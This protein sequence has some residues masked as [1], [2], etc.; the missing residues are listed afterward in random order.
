MRLACGTAGP[1]SQGCDWLGWFTRHPQRKVRWCGLVRMKTWIIQALRPRGLRPLLHRVEGCLFFSDLSGFNNHKTN[2]EGM[3]QEREKAAHL[4][5]T[6]LPSHFEKPATNGSAASVSER[7]VK[8][9]AVPDLSRLRR[10]TTPQFWDIQ[11]QR[12]QLLYSRHICSSEAQGFPQ[13]VRCCIS[14][15]ALTLLRVDGDGGWAIKV[16]KWPLLGAFR[17]HVSP[18]C[19]PWLRLPFAFP[20]YLTFFCS[21]PFVTYYPAPS[22]LLLHCVGLNQ[23][24]P[25]QHAGRLM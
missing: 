1:V 23:A 25:A 8:L 6:T 7:G 19:P 18:L 15:S 12:C 22:A 13:R 9:C 16:I 4:T 20:I 3:S 2:P 11:H 21:S 24:T 5:P 17:A 10:H 14:S